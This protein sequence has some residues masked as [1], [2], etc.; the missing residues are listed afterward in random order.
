L[1]AALEVLLVL[2][3][4]HA[5]RVAQSFVAV[6]AVVVVVALVVMVVRWQ[7]EV[8]CW[9]TVEVGSS[10]LRVVLEAEK[11]QVHLVETLLEA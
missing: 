1:E 2:L 9:C 8:H 11:E 3:R 6:V 5:A 4:M 7:V 10:A